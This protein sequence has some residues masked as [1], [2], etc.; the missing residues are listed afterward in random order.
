MSINKNEPSA[1]MK[2]YRYLKK[3]YND[4]VL[5]FRLGDFYELFDDDAISMSKILDLTLTSKSC[6]NEQ[7]APM[8][9]V[10]YHSAES[11]IN[12]LINL[13]Y[14][15]AICEQLTPAG[16]GKMVERDVVR[17]I[18]PGTVIDDGILDS[19]K[20]NYITCIYQQKQ[21]VGLAQCD[22]S[23]GEFIV[24]DYNGTDYLSN[25]NDFLNRSLP[26]E[27]ISLNDYELENIL[28]GCKLEIFPKFK[29]YNHEMFNLANSDI[30]LSK[31][32]GINYLQ[33][34]E[35]SDMTFAQ[36]ASGAL[37]SYLE[38]TQKRSLAHI[39][40][41]KKDKVNDY[42]LMDLNTRKNL[43]ILETLK[44]RRKK[45]A[46]LSV[47]DKTK[48]SMGS[49]LIKNW[50][51]KPLY[52][53][54]EINNRL[55]TVEELIKKLVQRDSLI[56]ILKNI[57]D[58]ERISGRIAYG[59]FSPKDAV[60]LK[61]SLKYIPEIKKELEK[62]ESEK[63]LNFLKNIPDFSNII[64]LLDDAFVEDPPAMLSVGNFIK[65]G[66][67]K[68]L[69]EFRDLR[70]NA[71]VTIN[72]LQ[73]KEQEVT[74]I[75]SLKISYN[76][77]T[78]YYIEIATSLAD[79]IP[80]RYIRK[81]TVSQKDRYITQEL[82]E[83]EEKID[84]AD[85]NAHKL[86]LNIFKEI[87]NILLSE[88]IK[89]QNASKIIAELDCLL[90]FS[91][92]SAKNNYTKPK[93]S[94][95]INQIKIVDGR[96]PVVEDL[97]KNIMFIPNDTLLDNQENKIMV[98]T[99]PNM[100]G[101][102]T[103]MRQVAL[104]TLLAHIGCFV[105]AKQAE[106]SLTDKIFTRVGASDDL[107]LGQSTFMVEMMEVANILDNAT[108]KSL[109]ILDEIGRGTSTFD[110]LSIAWAVIEEISKKMNCKTMFATHYHELT[111]LEGF[112][113]GIKNYKIAIKEINGELV[114]LRKIQRGGANRSY[115]IEVAKLAGVNENVIQ[116]AKAI[117]FELEKNDLSQ[118]I[119]KNV[120]DNH[121]QTQKLEKSYSGV[122]SILKDIDINRL[123]P[124][125][126]FE[127]LIDIVQKVK[128]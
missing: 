3:L 102:S 64:K 7:K 11:Y 128:N 32:F 25:L 24:A 27:I 55:N 14:S 40:K 60:A 45:G 15:V 103:Y 105:P 97:N 36:I 108:S 101:K 95:K 20:N 109:V 9:G 91:E 127:I 46:L 77:V 2:Q 18:T 120:S 107:A 79:K 99:G 23:T 98:I 33:E 5:F 29:D 96:H 4:C 111:E 26:S 73:A 70:D 118:H 106:I 90:S 31:Y 125:S 115:G 114:F 28:A 71:L 16:Q 13:G 61:N 51:Q 48:T 74:G 75:D 17:V 38:E 89:L 65:N 56:N 110:G 82:K 86:E 68:Q 113:S 69:D 93:I 116:R 92:I 49:R 94:S 37:L 117:S 8:C 88:C 121:E 100:A 21:R 78:G 35:I 66:F 87:R 126:A 1:M 6:G 59:N 12:K 119:V 34:Y 57:A 41:I 50:L 47:I 22:I 122:I 58:I 54:K 42:L 124:L 80:L 76:R 62:F 63:I 39:T 52:N 85:E 67:N 10:P 84:G 19:S 53:E 83:I 44:D 112:M 72:K 30:I 81:Q 43:E 104:I 123:S